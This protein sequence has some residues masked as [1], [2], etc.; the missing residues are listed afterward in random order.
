MA[1]AAK[2][3]AASAR[4]AMSRAWSALSPIGFS[5]RTCLPA[6]MAST[7]AAWWPVCGVQT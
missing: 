3:P 6:S 7:A 1:S 2:T 5:I 4:A